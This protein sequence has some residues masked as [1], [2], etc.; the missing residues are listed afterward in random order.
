MHSWMVDSGLTPHIVVD[1]TMDGVVVPEQFVTDGKIVLN[2]SYNA[3][4]ALDLANDRIAFNA[5]FEGTPHQ[6]WIP[7]PAVLGIYAKET[8]QGMVFTGEDGPAPP[9]DER[10]R[11]AHLKVVK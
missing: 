4:Q 2:L 8:G 7:L 10:P 9:S 6:I 3:T 1:A 11:A 5:R